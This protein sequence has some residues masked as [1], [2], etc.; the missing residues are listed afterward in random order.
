MRNTVY[1]L[2]KSYVTPKYPQPDLKFTV[3]YIRFMQGNMF[4]YYRQHL[5]G[6]YLRSLGLCN[7]ILD[8]EMGDERINRAEIIVVAQPYEDEAYAAIKNLREGGRV[9]VVDTDDY[10]HVMHTLDSTLAAHWT[11]EALTNYE[12]C[13]READLVTVSVPRIAERMEELNARRVVVIDNMLDPTSRRWQVETPPDDGKI[14]ILWTAGFTHTDDAEPIR[15]AVAQVLAKYPHVVF[16]SVGYLPLWVEALP[17]EQVEIFQTGD[18]ARYPKSIAGC[19]ISL[20][21]LAENK[22]NL[23]RSS[24]KGWEATCGGSVFVASN[25]GPYADEF[26]HRKTSM[27][28]STTSEWVEALS[29]LIEDEA[30]RDKLWKAASLELL[31]NRS[32]ERKVM[33]YYWAYRKTVQKRFGTTA[34]N[35]NGVPQQKLEI[36]K[37]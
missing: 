12:N 14:R 33:Q 34:T 21:P 31:T 7:V 27:L 19:D 26:R 10:P 16:R 36:V 25:Y 5:P 30:L 29:E 32:V 18:V 2:A 35:G 15:E 1:D 24:V 28:C 20:G 17:P 8:D 6:N 37:R 9:V 4:G 22:I 3:T 13:V 23:Y 11:P